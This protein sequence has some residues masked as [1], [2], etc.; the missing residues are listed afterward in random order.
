M[1]ALEGI[2]PLKQLVRTVHHFSLFLY[3]FVIGL[4]PLAPDNCHVTSALERHIHTA[5]GFVAQVRTHGTNIAKIFAEW[6]T[7]DDLGKTEG[8]IQVRN[9]YS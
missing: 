2:K 3:L 1:R 7:Q 9:T 6:A 5:V 4:H 8:M